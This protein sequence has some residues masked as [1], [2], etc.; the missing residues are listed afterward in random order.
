ME[1]DVRGL[2]PREGNSSLTERSAQ[3][4][5]DICHFN[6]GFIADPENMFGICYQLPCKFYS[7]I[8]AAVSSPIEGI[9]NRIVDRK[10]HYLT[11]L[12]REKEKIFL[13]ILISLCSRL[14]FVSL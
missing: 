7:Y 6:E 8:W 9:T 11:V 4:L 3:L 5:G 13:N 2:R 12:L 1:N 10:L 14:I